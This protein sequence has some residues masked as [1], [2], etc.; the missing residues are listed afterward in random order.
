MRDANQNLQS[1]SIWTEIKVDLEQIYIYIIKF[2]EFNSMREKANRLLNNFKE[3]ERQISDPEVMSDQ[4]RYR[5]LLRQH[6]SLRAARLAEDTHRTLERPSSADEK[7]PV[8]LEAQG[9][10]LV[11]VK[12]KAVSHKNGPVGFA[13]RPAEGKQRLLF[14]RRF[15]LD[16]K[17]VEGRMLEVRSVRRQRELDIA[18]E[19]QAAGSDGPVAERDPPDLH[20][21]LRGDDDLRFGVNAVVGTPEHG[22]VERKTG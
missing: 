2:W 11:L 5:E 6:K 7:P 12:G 22:T 18:G 21:V 15:G 4:M 20:I 19:T 10:M 9:G 16:E 14:R 3:L 8:G 17:F 1:K 13:A